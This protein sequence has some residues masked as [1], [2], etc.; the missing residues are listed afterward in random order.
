MMR[1]EKLALKNYRQFKEIEVTFP[2]TTPN[3][4]HVVIG[5]NGTGK[6]NI[7]NAINWCLYGEE[8][9][10][11][12]DSQA[13]PILNLDAIAG[14]EEGEDKTVV[15]EVYFKTGDDKRIVFSREEVYTVYGGKNPPKRQ[16]TTFEVRT[17]DDKGNCKI[18]VDEEAASHVERFVPK[19]IREF[20]FFDGE[21]LDSYFKEATAQK[22]RH[23]IFVISQI[24]LLESKVERKLNELLK[25][26]TKDAGRMNPSIEEVSRKLEEARGES[27]ETERLIDECN[28]EISI[29][30]NQLRGYEERLRG[31]PDLDHLRK[32]RLERRASKKHNNRLREEKV[33][34]KQDVLFELGNIIMLWPAVDKSMKIIDEKTRQ[35]EIPPNID[36]S[37]LK[38]ILGEK[39]CTI[40]GNKLDARA[41]QQVNDLLQEIKVSS[42]I[43]KHLTNMQAP[44]RVA[45]HK[46][47]EFVTRSETLSREIDSYEKELEK[48]EKRMNDIEKELSGYNEKNVK[49][50]VEQQQQFQKVLETKQQH[51]GVLKER[52]KRL[53]PEI[54]ELEKNFDKEIE[55]E[56]KA[57]EIK[58]QNDFCKK[59][60][61]I[62]RK[63]KELIMKRTR[64]KIQMKTNDLFFDLI[65]KKETFKNVSITEDY[66]I[67]L[68]HSMGYNCLGSISAAERELLALSF[69]L[70][71]HTVSGFDSPILIDT[72]VARVSDQHRENFAKSFSQVS[73]G[74]QIILLFTPD[75]YS[76]DIRNIIDT[77]SSSRSRLRL[78]AD[79]R[80]T[81]LE[82]L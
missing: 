48:I 34:E 30:H 29:A 15:A 57:K 58:R 82:V 75:E 43:A 56:E 17:H 11:A 28:K 7:L 76:Q 66:E 13:L 21:R 52:E 9:H 26:L 40:C 79:E 71:L 27:E 51:L 14:A 39:M 3:D 25:D 32:E 23:A 8:P 72:P 45:E 1:V 20:F 41:E 22:I 63:T 64:E 73:M 18:C 55:K 35:G 37:L 67:N 62:V 6:T 74:K 16:Q 61:D 80:E 31:I 2:K 10:L 50:W 36:P 59:S 78:L 47:K 12:K 46:M 68:I 38:G 81:Q 4:L 54:D 24:E 33:R 53:K 42:V 49:N 69:T 77:T 44:L 65:W 60:L 19:T 5:R 70:A